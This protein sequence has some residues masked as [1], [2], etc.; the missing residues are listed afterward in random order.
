MW[1]IPSTFYSFISW[2]FGVL[3]IMSNAAINIHVHIFVWI[4]ALISLEY[5]H[6][7]NVNILV[8][9][10][11][12]VEFCSYYYSMSSFE[13][14]LDCFPKYLSFYIPTINMWGSQFLH[15]LSDV[16]YC[17]PFYYSHHNGCEV[18]S[19]CGFFFFFCI[20]MMTNNFNIFSCVYRLFV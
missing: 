11:L 12:R 8:W 2:A 19:Y 17:Q 3:M 15:I 10:E 7:G 14:L 13:E 1:N 20:S 16:C 5:M 9:L 18:L 4:Y 6:L